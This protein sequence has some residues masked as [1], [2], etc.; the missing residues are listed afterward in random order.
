MFDGSPTAS[1]TRYTQRMGRP[2][3][4][5][6]NAL[7]AGI[8]DPALRR[9]AIAGSPKPVAWAFDLACNG[10]RHSIVGPTDLLGGS[11][12][13]EERKAAREALLKAPGSVMAALLD[14]RARLQ[15]THAAR[16]AAAVRARLGRVRDV[17]EL[18]GLGQGRGKLRLA[19]RPE[20]IATPRQLGALRHRG[21]PIP[22]ACTKREFARLIGMHAKRAEGGKCSLATVDWLGKLG[23]AGQTLSRAEAMK[24]FKAYVEGGARPMDAA[25]VAKALR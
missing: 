17:F 8:E 3:R 20:D 9:A 13:P 4:L 21:I 2:M 25:S 10:V 11:F 24:V 12:L 15:E 14:A 5:H 7:V 6:S 22:P 16:A 19:P 23:V 18:A 1:A